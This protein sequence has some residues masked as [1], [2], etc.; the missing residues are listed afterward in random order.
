LLYEGS[1][2]EYIL[3]N[4]LLSSFRPLGALASSVGRDTSAT[5]V[6]AGEARQLCISRARATYTPACESIALDGHAHV[7]RHSHLAL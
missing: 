2:G 1:T 7:L 4:H 6:S 5:R 3:D